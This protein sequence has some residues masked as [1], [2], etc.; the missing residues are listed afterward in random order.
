MSE[1]MLD[2]Q[3]R[4]DDNQLRLLRKDGDRYRVVTSQTDWP[5][6]NGD[7]SGNRYTKLT[8]I[9]KSNVARAGA[10]VDVP[11][12]ERVDGREHA[13]GCRRRDVRFER[14]RMLGAR[15]GQRTHDLAFPARRAPKAWPATPPVG[16]NRGVAV[17]GDRIFMLTDNAHIIA[18]NRFTGELLWETEMA[19]WHQNYNGTSAPLA[20][21]NHGGL[22]N[23]RRR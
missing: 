3:L 16:F 2:L 19:D 4:T 23:R 9:D 15:R 22:R 18:L 21:G 10:E 1:G 20:V 5:T 11:A 17:A 13:G 7:P 14:Q 8:Q 6:Y 12:A